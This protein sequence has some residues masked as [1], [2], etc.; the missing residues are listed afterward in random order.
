MY[1]ANWPAPRHEAWRTLLRARA[2]E[3]L[4]AVAAVNRCGVDGNGHP[5]AGGSAVLDALGRAVIEC[6]DEPG[7]VDA[8]LSRVAQDA[9]RRRFP[10]HLD[11]DGF[12]L[13]D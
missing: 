1:V 3:N 5:Y 8:V 12:S 4:A 6:G 11:A 2:I 7:V 13:D 10:A 9:H